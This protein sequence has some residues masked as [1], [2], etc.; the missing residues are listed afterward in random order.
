MTGG[1]FRPL[2]RRHRPHSRA[3]DTSVG[4]GP[5]DVE[6]LTELPGSQQISCQKTK[7]VH[8][9][10]TPMPY[11]T[12]VELV[13]IVPDLRALASVETSEEVRAALIR[14]AD[15]YAAMADHPV[16]AIAA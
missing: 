5:A 16:P 3:G 11:V 9:Q 7:M 13:E 15:R 14:L 6:L 8:R 12:E 4:H 1:A 2:R 10:E